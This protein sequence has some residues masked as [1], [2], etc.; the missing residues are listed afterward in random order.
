[1]TSETTT[2]R[3][4]KR[5][6]LNIALIGIVVPC[7]IGVAIA[8]LD[9]AMRLRRDRQTIEWAE[10]AMKD[11][12]YEDAA[13]QF[14]RAVARHPDN[15]DLSLKSGDAYYA[16]SATKPE[17]LQKARIAWE[18]VARID[19][20]NLSAL[21]R[22]IRFQTDL[23]EVRPTTNSLHALG[24]IAERVAAVSPTDKDAVTARAVASLGPWFSQPAAGG[25]AQN[26][27]HDKLLASLADGVRDNPGSPREIL[28]FALAS[29]RRAM[30]L[31]SDRG[32]DPARQVLDKAERQIADTGSRD[33]SSLY[34]CAQGLKVLSE[35]NERL[36]RI[37]AS[38]AAIAATSRPSTTQPATALGQS[39]WP[40]WD[41]VDQQ[42]KWEGGESARGDSRRSDLP[43]SQPADLSAGRCLREARSLAVRAA[44]GLSASDELFIDLRM[45]QIHLAEA[46]G[47]P[48]V[49]EQTCRETL[50]ARPGNLRVQLELAELVSQAHP[51]EALAVLAESEKD[52][53]LAAGPI[54]LI[55]RELLIRTSMQKARLYLDAAGAG[56]DASARAAD[57]EKADAACEEL[58]AMLVN[59]APSLTLTGRLRMLQGR[60]TEAVRLLDNAIAMAPRNVKLD[61]LSYRA[62]S[63]LALHQSQAALDTLRLAL[64]SDPSG[65]NERL[66]LAQT[67]IDEGRISEAS[68]QA[69]LLE[70][71]IPQDPR[72]LE[73]RV[74]LLIAANAAEADMASVAPA[75]SK[76]PEE[77]VTQKLT[78]AELALSS[79]QGPDAIRLLKAAQAAE[80]TSVP[81]AVDLVRAMIAN[82]QLDQARTLLSD[83]V[84]QH[85]GDS[86]L[87]AVQRSLDG[88]AS[89]E[90]SEGSIKGNSA[91][92]F[93]TAVHACRA[94]LE[95]HDLPRAKEQVDAAAKLRAED[96]LLFDLKFAYDL[97]AQQWADAG[98]CIDH[99]AKANLDRMEGLSYA[100][101][102]DMARGQPFA[103]VCDARQMALR[104][105]Q[106]APAWNDLGRAL[107]AL[108]RYDLAID[109]FRHA[110]DLVPD[111]LGTIKEL[112]ACFEQ[113]GREQEADQ[114]I[115]KG[116][117]LSPGDA[118]LRDM[119]LVRQLSQDN[120]QRLVAARKAAVAK[121]PQRPDNLIALARVYLRI[122]ALENLAHPR[123]AKDALDQA[124]VALGGAVKQS[125]DDQTCSFWA[126]HAAALAGDVAGGKQILRRL[127]DRPAWAGRPEAEQMLADFCLDWGDPQSAEVA[128]REAMKRGGSGA[129]TA[130][131]LSAA[132]M[133]LGSWQAALDALREYPADPQVQQQRIAIFIAAGKGLEVEKELQIGF[134]ANP[135]D[136]H[137][138][139]LFGMLYFT[140]NDDARAAA[141]LD[142]GFTAGDEELAGRA[143]GALKLRD[144]TADL[145]GALGDLAIAHE[146]HPSD[147]GAAVL[148]GE[149]RLRNHDEAGARRSLET[150]LAITPSDK[151]LRWSLIALERNG[152][153]P[154]WARIVALIEAGRSIAPSDWDWDVAESRMWL[155]RQQPG[156][157]AAWL[158]RAVQ[159]ASAAPDVA[160]VTLERQDA[161]KV[162]TLIPEELWV[163]LQAQ[164]YDAV[165]AEA[166]QVISRYGQ[167]DMLAAWGHQ[168]RAA[169]QRRSGRGDGGTAE[170]LK[171]ISIAQATGGYEAASAVVEMISTEA[172]ADEAVRRINDYVQAI[173]QAAG[174]QHETASL[175]DPRW[176]LL[177]IDLL[178]R[179][180]ET[181]AAASE[182]DKQMPHLAELPAAKQVQLLR[183]A[184]V[185]YLRDEP[186]PQVG[187]AKSAC[188][189]LLARLPEDTWALNNMAA[190]CIEYSNPSDPQKALEYGQHAY[191]AAKESGEVD[192]QIVDT[193][194]WALAV[195][196]RGSE[197]IE[198]LKPLVPRMTTP[199]TEYHLAEA[200]LSAGFPQ[201]AGAHLQSA[202]ELIRRD[203][204]Q[205]R[206]VDPKLRTDIAS[207][208]WRSLGQATLWRLS[209][210]MQE[211]ASPN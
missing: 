197:A 146:A 56:K 128:L 118:E 63:L 186:A 6:S 205:G 164:A 165:L 117:Q 158:H 169:V 65:S 133:Q 109:S 4:G 36:D 208:F 113:A 176:D 80:P 189:A 183:M 105:G 184:V 140:G 13:A 7:V 152:A 51:Q 79:G 160:D 129:A 73:L 134:A 94:A 83:A 192:P 106:F 204:K 35:A 142:R 75:Y 119:E 52:K 161:R 114:W 101:R 72:V 60:Y 25:A 26:R 182:I 31:K 20:Q 68:R 207:A 40:T 18:A 196:G 185:T 85:P 120:P 122:S 48:G 139:T 61:L 81:A 172:G 27:T 174:K 116:R 170:Y 92:E 96:P 159:L 8:A 199:E 143:R 171:A 87:T 187:K 110:A 191:L 181:H 3:P 11:G 150:A 103:A 77:S 32:I 62:T 39:M 151:D 57:L 108:G 21:H 209:H 93:L 190:I 10:Q 162:R 157:A 22:L 29:S 69:D 107:R 124:V 98:L 179:N 71:K 19:P 126:A 49:A 102:R 15:A 76:L 193:Y 38:D 125:P 168:A 43:T 86:S 136:A 127:C 42:V 148:L 90:S 144:K 5:V 123:E 97:A 167:S 55:R 66:L 88:S 138:M 17:S 50:A 2:P 14:A 59:N 115:S 82:N 202:L 9:H 132:L 1:M 177:R 173:D 78:K 12:R 84:R 163:L 34:R 58:A 99:L 16:L 37:P 53:E 137:V 121:E 70:A 95:A 30:E 54:V 41:I 130:R 188:L 154:D 131:Q 166:D 100:F 206:D 104:Y 156:K 23:A 47:D 198:V 28:Y 112:A 203:Q 149:A 111:D 153:A 67:L 141:W 147:G 175:H 145:A 24:E 200:Y 178:N 64:E 91:K 46:S 45:L 89:A 211:P 74:R 195:A 201:S 210:L 194:G 135:A 44:Q 155:A 33:A 180:R